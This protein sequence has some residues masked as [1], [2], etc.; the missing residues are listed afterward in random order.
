MHRLNN[1]WSHKYNNKTVSHYLYLLV[2]LVLLVLLEEQL[3]LL[4]DLSAGA[5]PAREGSGEQC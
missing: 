3:R 4:E 2:L 1:L 5:V